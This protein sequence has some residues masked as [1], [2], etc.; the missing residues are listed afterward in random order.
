MSAMLRQ[1]AVG[2]MTVA[3]LLLAG[4][5]QTTTPA[6]SAESVAAKE[7]KAPPEPVT[8]RTAFG[9]MYTPA[10]QWSKDLVLLR[11]TPRDVPGF[12]NEAG[13]AAMWQA[14]FASPSEHQYRIY[15][16]AIANAPPDIY[17]GVIARQPSP[18]GGG[19]RDVMPIDLS[20]FNIDSDAAYQA[21]TADGAAW[22]KKNPTK[23]LSSFA[24]GDSD[25]FQAPV[26]LLMWGDKKSGYLA[27]VDAN[28]G[29]VLKQKQ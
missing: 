22:L 7:S 13:K 23:E 21:A 17:K 24:L 6:V 15:Y 26:W 28:S 11:L 25:R 18:W 19:T 10:R 8:A 4:C 27:Y 16:Y 20:L 12:K 29:K 3:V 2:A 14:T 1:C 5:S 9:A